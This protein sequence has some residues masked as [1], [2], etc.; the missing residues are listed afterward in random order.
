MTELMKHLL[1]LSEE[2]RIIFF[3]LSNKKPQ[4]NFEQRDDLVSCIYYKFLS[5]GKISV[6]ASGKGKMVKNT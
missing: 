2:L 4:T 1:Q 5:S 6:D 3:P